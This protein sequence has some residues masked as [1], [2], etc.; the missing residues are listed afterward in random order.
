[1]NDGRDNR[2]SRPMCIELSQNLD[3]AFA[4]DTVAL[5][6]LTG[7]QGCF[8]A[9]YDLSELSSEAAQRALFELV[10]LFVDAPKPIIAGIEGNAFGAGLEL[11]LLCSFRLAAPSALFSYPDFGHGLPPGAGGSQMLPRIL[12]A[13]DSLAFLTSGKTVS[14][15]GLP[16]V[17]DAEIQGDFISGA[18]RFA[19]S[20]AAQSLGAISVGD[21]SEGL[22]DPVAFQKEIAD[23]R[24]NHGQSNEAFADVIAAIE[25]ALLLPFAAGLQSEREIFKAAEARPEARAKRHLV[26]QRLSL[27]EKNKR[28]L[29]A[30]DQLDRIAILGEGDNGTGSA[31]R[32]LL[33]GKPVTLIHGAEV[34]SDD[35][36]FEVLDVARSEAR[37]LGQNAPD[38]AQLSDQLMLSKDISDC[39]TADILLDVSGGDQEILRARAEAL[40]T[41]LPAHAVY[42]IA[43]RQID[44]SDVMNA[45]ARP[46]KCAKLWLDA[47]L[48]QS[49]CAYSIGGEGHSGSRGLVLR[50]LDHLDLQGVETRREAGTIEV[51]LWLRLLQAAETLCIAG[52]PMSAV[53]SAL[54]RRGFGA[55]PFQMADAVGLDVLCRLSED[56]PGFDGELKLTRMLAEDG[57]TGVDAWAG[58]YLCQD[59]RSG[60]PN[61]V[62]TRLL[63][64]L[65]EERGQ[66]RAD[67]EVQQYCLAVL[68]NEAARIISDGGIAS[69]GELDLLLTE[70]LGLADDLG[71]LLHAADTEGLLHLRYLLNGQEGRDTPHAALLDMIKNGMNFSS[72]AAEA[73]RFS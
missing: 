72:L 31:A 36:R 41:L 45:F 63:Q 23:A 50:L 5:V 52:T 35:L 51:S 14:A 18:K 27:I 21:R 42:A 20:L 67:L 4:D 25:T 16:G 26:H 13:G 49:L 10:D 71:G 37:R 43:T 66:K 34:P 47:E 56:L 22:S 73:Q 58:F 8:S 30:A 68:A 28:A 1:M 33:A 57:Q 48:D 65:R 60:V 29:T 17:V 55:G 32:L 38:A 61:P 2:L 64:S 6:L 69:A 15:A 54:A 39:A 7:T 24:R 40:G 62:A 12:G 46:S 9:G 44:I 53:D 11:A 3:A 70:E 59:D 19:Q